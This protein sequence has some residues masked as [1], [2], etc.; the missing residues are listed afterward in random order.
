MARVST[1]RGYKG[2]GDFILRPIAGGKPFNLGNVVSLNES[3]EVNRVSRQNYRDAAG[4]ELD[5]EETITGYT[6]E[7]VADD[8]SP[9]NIALGFRGSS[10]Q[11]PSAAVADEPQQLWSEIP[12]ALN[13]IPDMDQTVTVVIAATASHATDTDYAVGDLVIESAR[14]YMAVVAGQSGSSAPSW[15]TDLSTVVDG[16][17]TWKDLGPAA[18]VKDTDFEVTPH[19]IR[20]MASQSAR[21]YEELSI[22]V[23]CS[24]TR[25]AQYLVRAL[26]DS[27]QEF[28]CE[29]HG[30]NSVD[31]GNPVVG[32]YF[33][34]K[35]SPT[36]GFGRHGGDD[37]AQLTLSGTVLFDESREGVGVSK[38]SEISM[39]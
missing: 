10:T 9:E 38:Y 28:Y 15:P 13:Y 3:I 11:L 20:M 36:S 25:D 30:L 27:G 5:V 39:I 1:T 21:F 6:F 37:F 35:F 2:R 4:G 12:Q 33:R 22:P 32:R 17:V 18:L 26:V 34:I 23:T 19:G 8:I 24:Y 7:A 31:G 29:W 14:A 16:G